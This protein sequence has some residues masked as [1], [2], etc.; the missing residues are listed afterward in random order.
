MEIDEI[1]LCRLCEIRPAY[2]GYWCE[3]CLK[4]NPDPKKT[5]YIPAP[6]ENNGN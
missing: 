1:E 4:N 3:P 2:W 6:E 5:P